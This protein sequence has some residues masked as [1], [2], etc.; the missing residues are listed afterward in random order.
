[1]HMRNR[2]PP[3]FCT[4]IVSVPASGRPAADAAAMRDLMAEA[5]TRD[6]VTALLHLLTRLANCGLDAGAPP[7]LQ[8][9]SSEI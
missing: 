9:A 7:L 2:L 4:S 5:H 8:P 1:M 6:A 3:D